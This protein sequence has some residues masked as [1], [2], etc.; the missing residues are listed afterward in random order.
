MSRLD[1]LPQAPK[2]ADAQAR[3][4]PMTSGAQENAGSSKSSDFGSF[5]DDFSGKAQKGSMDVL[6]LGANAPGIEADKIDSK[7]NATGADPL[8]ALLPDVPV[9]DAAAGMSALPSGSPAFSFLENMIPRILA[10]TGNGPAADAGQAGM[11]LASGYLSMSQQDGD[12]PDPAHSG[13]GSRLAVSV[14]NQETHFKPI[15]EGVSGIASEPGA[16]DPDAQ[17]E[18][19]MEN[20]AAGKHK[21]IELRDQQASA[22][23]GL[24]KAQAD[25]AAKAENARG[26]EEQAIVKGASSARMSDQAEMPK[27]SALNGPKSDAASLPPST[28]QHIASAVIEDVKGTS[29]AQHS[30]FQH[31]DLNRAAT[32]RASASVLRVLDLQLKPA[33][34]GL[35]T[36]RM[37]LA[38]DGIEMEIQ[39]QNEET[40]E[41]LRN[42]AEKLSN[43]LRGSGYRPDVI[44][45][46]SSEAASHDRSSFHRP[47]QGSQTQG[48]SFDQGAAGHGSSSR[49]QGE[50]NERDG[51]EFHKDRNDTSLPGGSRTGGVYL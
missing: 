38:G 44:N 6:Q 48:Q 14:Q 24:V 8:Q 9:S 36:I 42:D 3:N 47:P 51:R 12:T 19:V 23:V 17:V 15:I 20:M 37:R 4:A 2:L 22:G 26:S 21:P 43:L 29:D 41:L 49:H 5:L 40:A 32:A 50:R 31:T 27:Q 39:A 30:S 46:Q 34:L 35:V 16:S 33:E 10:Q 45:I 18:P 1:L 25:L 13:L 7:P 11:A 28:L